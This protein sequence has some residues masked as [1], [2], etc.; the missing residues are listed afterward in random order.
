MQTRLP[1]RQSSLNVTPGK[2]PRLS[3]SIPPSA[4]LPR[5]IALGVFFINSTSG[6]SNAKEGDSG[7]NND[8]SNDAL[9]STNTLAHLGITHAVVQRAS[10]SASNHP[11]FCGGTTIK[12][13]FVGPQDPLSKVV[14]WMQAVRRRRGAHIIVVGDF[15]AAAGYLVVE[16]GLNP[17]S[18]W[19]RIARGVPPA[20]DLVLARL[21]ALAIVHGEKEKEKRKYGGGLAAATARGL[22]TEHTS[23]SDADK[24]G[25][26]G[27][28]YREFG[29]SPRS[30]RSSRVRT[31]AESRLKHAVVISSL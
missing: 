19:L 20:G 22:D 6:S 2:K 14:A 24:E 30:C 8:N 31:R 12:A 26:S 27:C 10:A 25:P 23:P 5:R 15:A 1:T 3:V 29:I 16:L 9:P 11:L 7:D 28:G 17:R 21:C 4:I 13:L 18:A